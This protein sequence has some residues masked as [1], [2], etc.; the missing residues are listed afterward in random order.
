MTALLQ[1]HRILTPLLLGVAGFALNL[2]RFEIF[3]NVDFIFGSA[4][5]MLAM[6]FAGA[7]SGGLAALLAGSATLLLWNH[8]WAMAIG[9]AEVLCV[10][11]LVRRRSWDL[12]LADLLF[13]L[14]LGSPLV[15]LAYHDLLQVPAQPTLLI[16]LK[17]S[18]NGIVNTLLASLVHK[19]WRARL[20]PEGVSRPAFRPAVFATLVSLVTLPALL[21]LAGF[22]RREIR[23]EEQL[24]VRRSL[25]IEGI[26]RR[27]V[28]DWIGDHHQAVITLAG[29][30]AR[31]D[32]SPADRQQATE[33]IRSASP[34]FK[35]V[36]VLDSRAI[37]TAYS[38]PVDAQGRSVLG[39]DFSDRPYIPTLKATRR[40]YV[41]DLVLG[42]IGPT[43]PI[44]PLLAPVLREGQYAGYCIGVTDTAPIT[45]LLHTIAGRGGAQLTLL[46][47][48]GRVVSSTRADL[49]LMAAY[50]PLEGEVQPLGEGV[51]HRIPPP[52]PGHSRMQR[53]RQSVATRAMDI[54]P[55][56]PWRVVVE[57]PFAPL[58]DSLTRI[59]I[60]GLGTLLLLILATVALAHTLSR[61]FTRAVA[62]LEAAT[63]AFPA[64]LDEAPDRPLRVPPS[65]IEELH[66]LGRRFEQMA[67][68]LRASFQELRGLKDTLEERVTQRTAELQ[69]AL[70]A[71][72]TLHGI[73]PICASCK[74]IR[75]DQGAW[76]QLESYISRH[77]EATFSH[78]ICPDCA[79]R[80][81]PE[82]YQEGGDP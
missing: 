25:E 47:R 61:S 37:V 40:P 74:K 76:N 77:T 28:G 9:T 11:W 70:D 79:K 73:L 80:L 2:L 14:V 44:F 16:I 23:H 68:A 30:E 35:R 3:F 34:A 32:L 22:L 52:L 46:D 49:P 19:L 8:P 71:L 41:A 38:P 67:E 59:S 69:A 60:Y 10:G 12:L 51:E 53:W 15:W 78:G 63:R 42:R 43:A 29:L 26:A 39:R 21:F 56:L 48:N 62:Q 31:T 64:F 57:L 33:I 18:V 45:D 7:W 82:V 72:R 1:R 4:F 65:G 24:L 58:I 5:A 20:R 6:L 50:R 54:S 17:Q 27:A 13:W 36:G 66:H 75:D 55:E 81:Y